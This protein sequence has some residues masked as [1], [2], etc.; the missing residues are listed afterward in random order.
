MATPDPVPSGRVTGPWELQVTITPAPGSGQA[1][2]ADCR[3]T[4]RWSNYQ[5]GCGPQLCHNIYSMGWPISTMW[6]TLNIS[7]EAA[8]NWPTSNEGEWEQC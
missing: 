3:H 5:D 6:N 1:G 8:G 2:D 4:G 7:S